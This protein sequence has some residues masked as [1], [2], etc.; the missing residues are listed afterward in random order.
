MGALSGFE[1]FKVIARINL[2]VGLI[3]VPMNVAGVYWGG[4]LGAVLATL[5][6]LC[7]TW[8]LSHLAVRKEC[9]RA[10]I[11]FAY[12]GCWQENEILWR[13]SL[14]AVL[15][16]LMVS[17]V[18]WLGS[19]LL[20][21][22]PGGYAEMGLYN[23]ILR[24]K[25]VPEAILGYL[26]RPLLPILSEQ[27]GRGAG[28][29]YARTLRYAY[30]ISILVMVP[31]S[32]LQIA[33]PGLTVLPYGSQY[34]GNGG[35]VRLLM[36]QAM[37]VGLF[38]PMEQ[39]LASMNKMW[40][41]FLVNILWA[42]AYLGLCFWF[43]PQAASKGLALSF[44]GSY[45]LTGALVLVYL[46]LTR[47]AVLRE[48]HMLR[49][50]LSTVLLCGCSALLA[51]YCGPIAAGVCALAGSAVYLLTVFRLSLGRTMN[52]HSRGNTRDLK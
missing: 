44:S 31:V 18:T 23:A 27:L 11:S 13:F 20:V 39:I 35:T 9:S 28:G 22:Q 33:V 19:A 5:L 12:R 15:A 45:L 40:F 52:I 37:L 50:A 34:A 29:E 51:R 21:N 48:V 3:N 10:G 41:G 24:I 16:G 47:P 42:A 49:L 36:V 7:L 38:S 26:I 8:F 6:S 2:Q 25:Q 4:L 17:P 1:S 43:V 14:P 46:F 32:A 30:G